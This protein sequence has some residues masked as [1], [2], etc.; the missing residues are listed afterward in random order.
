MT[1]SLAAALRRLHGAGGKAFVPYATAGLEGV[2]AALLVGYESAG[3]H[4]VEV[5]IPFSDPVMDGPVIQE[6]SGR[7]LESGTIPA[8][9]FALVRAARKAGLSAPVAFMTYLNPV[10][11]EGMEAFLDAVAGCGASGVIVPD[12]PVDEAGEWV[13]ACRARDVAPVLLAAPNSTPERL[14]AIAGSAAGFV[15]C[16]STF[17]V[18]GS[19]HEL[20]TSAE[21]V[22]G[23]LRPITETPL[24]V[25]VGI[26]TPEQAAEA[27][28]FA[29][30]VVVGSA[31]VE[32]MLAGDRD[33]ALSRARAF[34][35]AVAG[36]SGQE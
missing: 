33:E 28:G 10:L 32:P 5:G 20:S 7:A 21:V 16:V 30:G 18:T 17:G 13:A 11:A 9:A 15:Y 1:E 14:A 12:L 19:R 34:G 27:C 8:D 24:L 4:A 35:A 22:V 3:A 25:G 2:D 26:S 31:L 23:A 29:D 6:A 36:A